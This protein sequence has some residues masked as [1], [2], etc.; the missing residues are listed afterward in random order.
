[1]SSAGG[2]VPGNGFDMVCK[3]KAVDDLKGDESRATLKR[4]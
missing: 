2:T 1:M 4:A 3:A